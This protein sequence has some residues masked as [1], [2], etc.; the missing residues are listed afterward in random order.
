MFFKKENWFNF[1]NSPQ[2]ISVK[3]MKSLGKTLK[4]LVPEKNVSADFQL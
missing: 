1:I 4:I 2:N 3:G